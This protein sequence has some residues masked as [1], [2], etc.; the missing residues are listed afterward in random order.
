MMVR[1]SGRLVFVF[2]GNQGNS[3]GNW[4]LHF[5]ILVRKGGDAL[6]L[7]D[8]NGINASGIAEMFR[9]AMKGDGYVADGL[10]PAFIEL[11]NE[12]GDDIPQLFFPEGRRLDGLHAFKVY[13]M[14]LCCS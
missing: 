2:R 1:G 12:S 9:L 10:T 5:K 3:T 11:M 8:G 6:D 13:A 7:F 4:G 14:V